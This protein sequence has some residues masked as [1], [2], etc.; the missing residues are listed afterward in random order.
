MYQIIISHN[1][2]SGHIKTVELLNKFGISHITKINDKEMICDCGDYIG[3]GQKDYAVIN[4]KAVCI[5]CY[6]TGG[7]GKSISGERG[8]SAETLS[9]ME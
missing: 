9:D 4:G 3:P 6:E 2:L 8:A 5:D 1:E 7:D